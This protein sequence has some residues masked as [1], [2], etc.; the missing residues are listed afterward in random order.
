MNKM[1]EIKMEKVV[2][3]IGGTAENLEKGFKLLKMLTGKNPAKMQSR[4]RIPALGVRPGLEIGA[5]VTLRKNLD[6]FLKR[7]L[8]TKDN[9]LKK[10][11]VTENGFS[12]GVKEYIE[13]PGVEY[14]RDIGI[15][16]FDVSVAFKRAGRRVRLKK[17]KMG[18]IPKR[19]EIKKEEIIKFMEEKFNTNFV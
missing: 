4:K 13:I 7:M 12:F 17:I 14:Q 9:I 6:D 5:V 15:R 18:K 11:Q 10:S 19:N 8:A 2:L 3:S 16:G 1:R